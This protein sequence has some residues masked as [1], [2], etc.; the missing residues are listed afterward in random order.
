MIKCKQNNG[1]F[2]EIPIDNISF[3]PQIYAVILNHDLTEV[4]LC[5]NWDG[6]D[7]PGGGIDIGETN[8]EALER[9]VFEETGLKI[10]PEKIF[11]VSSGMYFHP[12][13]QKGFH[14][15]LFYSTATITGGSINTDHFDDHEQN[16]A[17]QA[18][19]VP[20][21]KLTTIK[22]YNSVDSLD[23]INEAIKKQ[24]RA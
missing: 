6:Y 7:F 23:L 3:R 8:E 1:T 18:E 15:L 14:T 13:K 17:K 24:K 4:L 19:W 10:S 22:F 9:E 20:I 11:F 2:I 5:P 16:Y 21:K 12:V